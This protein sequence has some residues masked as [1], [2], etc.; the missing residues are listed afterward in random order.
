MDDYRGDSSEWEVIVKY[1]GDIMGV[2]DIYDVSVEILNES[3]AIIT[4]SSDKLNELS[5]DSRVEHIET[6]KALAFLINE[7]AR[8][9]CVYPAP[10]MEGLSGDGVIVAIID[11]GIDYMH[12]DFMDDSGATRILSVW[13]QR[14]QGTPPAG[15][16]HGAEYDAAAINEAIANGETLGAMDFIGHGTA[17][18]GIAAGNGRAV[19][20]NAGVAPKASLVVVCLGEQ[21]RMSFA[22]TTELMRAVKYVTDQAEALGMPIVIN[23][24]YGTNDGS[25]DDNSLFELFLDDM[26]RKW[27]TVIVAA[28]GNEG[29]GSHHYSA[30]IDSGQSVDAEFFTAPN[31]RSFY[32]SFWQNF[33]DDI[34]FDFILPNGYAIRDITYSARTRSETSDGVTVDISFGQPSYYTDA[35]EIFINVSSKETLPA[36]LWTLRVKAGRIVDGRFDM[37][38]PTIEQVGEATAF[39]APSAN[40]TMTLPATAKN[41]LSVGAYD[42]RIGAMADFSSRGFAR[43]DAYVKPDLVA[44]GV[45]VISTKAGGGYDSFT[46]TSVAAPFVAGGA[47]LMMEW[48]IVKGND[49][50]LYG[51][52]VKAFLRAGAERGDGVSYPSPLWGYGALCV[53]GSIDMLKS[54]V[55]GGVKAMAHDEFAERI[56]KGTEVA[57]SEDEYDNLSVEEFIKLPEVV[58]ICARYSYQF[59]NYAQ[60]HPYVKIGSVLDGGYVVAYTTISEVENVI[61]DMG[62]DMII[63]IPAPLSLLDQENLDAAG[64]IRA[65]R[66]PY[67]Q[68]SGSGVLVGFVDTG[69]DYTNSVFLYEDGS[70]KILSI[71]DQTLEGEI[72]AGM[73]FGARYSNDD[74]NAALEASD[75]HDLA[76]H[77][78]EDG[79]GTF[80]ASLAAGR[81]EGEYNGAAPDAEI[82]AVKLKTADPAY[83]KGFWS[84]REDELLFRSAEVMLGIQYILDE[85]RRVDRPVV[86]CVAL[87]TNAGGHDGL[88]VLEE[89]MTSV[90]R[91]PGVVICAAAGNEGGAARH[92]HDM[93]ERTG[94]MKDIEIRTPEGI[95]TL[96]VYLKNAYWDKLSV[97][98]KSP[99]GEIMNRVPSSPGLSFEKN[100]A[101][102][103]ARLTISYYQNTSHISLVKIHDPTPGIWVI[104]VYGDLVISGEFHL[105]LPIGSTARFMAPTA[106]YTVV[107]P[108]TSEGVITCGAYNS[109]DGSIYV[110]SSWGPSTVPTVLPDLLAPGVNVGGIYPNGPGVMS[111]TSVAAA[112]TAGACALVLQWGIA[113]KHEVG[114]NAI[115]VKA[116]IARGGGRR[117]DNE[118]YPNVQSG[119]GRLDLMKTFDSLREM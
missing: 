24:S 80:L 6:P 73:H 39:S 51:Q 22:R 33:V 114:M 106:N 25:H 3:Y 56:I 101:L 43:N 59:E 117:D 79:H 48:G 116:L 36:S 71:W 105:W 28:A 100:F 91:L 55:Q 107:V 64:I 38:L 5:R 108:A 42:Y 11:S 76:P 77:L 110:S 32:I 96:V 14:A 34:S 18:A 61:S 65:R 10:E 111:G 2:E 40:G 104:S 70:S 84:G 12:P 97:S 103:E 99:S 30:K 118:N 113:D 45:N 23:L 27:K 66:N 19:Q 60:E 9:S 46:G 68:L 115:R 8:A 37:W 78:D 57:G 15:F 89:Y 21:G 20:A 92:T 63:M 52:R 88:T 29:S 50:F 95:K 44:P 4:S 119:Y 1:N 47:A 31:L 69:I 90:T 94:D 86:I 82:V 75:P 49:P 13:D 112:I 87:G 41:V 62:S 7:G 72:P 67:L 85:A 17:V 81:E 74:I 54:Y 58:P 26:E 83:I 16:N 102:E 98:I 93:L 53:K 35:Q 109:E